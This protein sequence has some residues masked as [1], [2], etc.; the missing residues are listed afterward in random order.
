M[1]ESPLEHLPEIV[2]RRRK[3]CGQMRFSSLQY[4]T[5]YPVERKA[6]VGSTAAQETLTVRLKSYVLL[7]PEAIHLDNAD[8]HLLQ[9]IVDA[10]PLALIEYWAVDPDYDGKAFRSAWQAYRGNPAS[11]A[12]ALHVAT[13]AT[14]TVPPKAGPRMLCVRTVDVFGFEAEVVTVV[15]PA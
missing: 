10:N 15:E 4:L 13:A 2:A 7:S 5:I 14:I 1:S 6:S 3:P 12:D 11:D 8:R 9:Q